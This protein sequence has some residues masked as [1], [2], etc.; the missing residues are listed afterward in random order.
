MFSFFLDAISESIGVSSDLND[1]KLEPMDVSAAPSD[2]EAEM[3][4]IGKH[5]WF[6]LI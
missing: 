5:D 4:I 6:S 2:V 1:V 3:A